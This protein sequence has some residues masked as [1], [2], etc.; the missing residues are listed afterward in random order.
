M[1]KNIKIYRLGRKGM[2]SNLMLEPQLVLKMVYRGQIC[3]GIKR[4]TPSGQDP[5]SYL[6][7][8][9]ISIPQNQKQIE[10]CAN[11]VERLCQVPSQAGNQI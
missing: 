1:T 4:V 8:L 5:K 10:V 2:P 6:K 3:N 7:A 11:V 9:V